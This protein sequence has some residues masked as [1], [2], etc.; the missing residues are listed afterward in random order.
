MTPCPSKEPIL[1]FGDNT[2]F[3]AMKLKEYTLRLEYV[4][5]T[6]ALDRQCAERDT[7]A[8]YPL[9]PPTI[10]HLMEKVE[11]HKRN[12]L[13]ARNW[14]HHRLAVSAEVDIPFQKLA[15]AHELDP[16]EQD[17][18]WILFF[19]AVSPLYRRTYEE[20]CLYPFAAEP[21]A[22]LC[23]SSLLQLLSPIPAVQIKL[24]S[25]LR[26][27]GALRRYSLVRPKRPATRNTALAM[28]TLLYLKETV[29]DSIIGT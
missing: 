11:L 28:E 23:A 24:L 29:R 5:L 7:G 9:Y 25:Y 2:E 16:I 3:L 1:P 6:Q 18:I 12:Y 21:G 26:P 19:K 22:L 13:K 27:K 8:R 4:S 14:N 15:S 20:S 10:R 17:V